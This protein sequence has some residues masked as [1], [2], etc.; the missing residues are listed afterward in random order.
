VLSLFPS[1]CALSLYISRSLYEFVHPKGIT[2]NRNTYVKLIDILAA[3]W[4][5]LELFSI[6]DCSNHPSFALCQ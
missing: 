1:L 3:D 4:E 6:E 2:Y 5:V